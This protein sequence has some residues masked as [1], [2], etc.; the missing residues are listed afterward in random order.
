MR[1]ISRREFTSRRYGVKSMV[2]LV[3]D[4]CNIV[5]RIGDIK[6]GTSY[7]KVRLTYDG[8]TMDTE[9]VTQSRQ[10]SNSCASEGRIQGRC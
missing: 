8:S 4:Q 7:M 2:G 9:T 6:F 3:G 5:E 10:K 1:S